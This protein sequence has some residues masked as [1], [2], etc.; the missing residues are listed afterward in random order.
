[1]NSIS[2]ISI[3]ILFL[4]LGFSLVS[5]SRFENAT[6]PG[7]I[8]T[9]YPTLTC[10]AAEWLIAGDDNENGRVEVSYRIAGDDNWLPAMPLLRVPAGSTG[11][12]TRPT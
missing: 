1:M 10:L 3:H 9:P 7:D 11:N 6:I 4:I 8:S 5:S 12:R 2:R